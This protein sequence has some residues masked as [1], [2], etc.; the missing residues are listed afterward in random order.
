MVHFPTNVKKMRYMVAELKGDRFVDKSTRRLMFIVPELNANLKLF[1]VINFNIGI[2]AA[3]KVTPEIN[4]ASIRVENFVNF[5]DYFRLCLECVVLLIVLNHSYHEYL[6]ARGVGIYI[7]LNFWNGVDLLRQ[8]LFYY[9]VVLYVII[10]NDPIRQHPEAVEEMCSGTGKWM[11]FPKDAKLEEDYVFFSA[12][13][14]LMS[15]LLIFKFLAPFPKFG[16]F[17]HTMNEASKDLVNFTGVLFIL[18]FGFAIMGH[19]LFGHVLVSYPRY[20]TLP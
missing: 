6:A 12:L 17:V 16:I 9:C 1:A 13:C 20:L 18:L 7:Y 8:L 3:G 14:L 2:D 11:N 15:T 5:M 4:I 19:I 10:M